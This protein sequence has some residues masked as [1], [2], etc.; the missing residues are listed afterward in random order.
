MDKTFEQ[1]SLWKRNLANHGEADPCAQARERLRQAFIKTRTAVIPLVAQI[2]KELPDLTVHDISHLDALWDVADVLMGDDFDINPAETF[3]LGM[4]FLMHDAAC[5]TFAF[6]DGLDNL[7]NTPEW[8][9]FVAQNNFDEEAMKKGGIGYQRTLFETLRLLHA[10]QAE[11]LLTQSWT[12][13][14]GVQRYLMDDVE[15]RNHY[16]RDIGK[17]AASHGKDAAVAEH[18]WANAAPLTPHACLKLDAKTAWKVDSLKIAMLLR[19]IDAAHID[20][21]RAPDMLASIAP[22]SG[23][24]A[25]YWRFQNR[26]GDVAI[27]K[28]DE[29][30]WSGQTFEEKASDA[31]WLCYDTAR[32]IDREIRNANII[33]TNNDRTP[34]RAKGVAGAQDAVGFS[35]NVPVQGW[36]PIDIGYQISQIGDVIEKFGGAKLYGQNPHLALRE[37]IQN[38]ADAIRARR[39]YRNKPDLG[40][41]DITLTEENGAWWLHVQDSGIGM[42]RYVLTDVLLDFGRSLWADASLREEWAGLAG[43]KFEAV[44]QF[45]I[46]FFSVFMLGDEIKVT[47]WRDGDAEHNQATLHLRQRTNG[48]PIL[49]DTPATQR[50]SEFGTRVSVRL[51]NGRATLLKTVDSGLSYASTEAP[52]HDMT[53]SE[54]VGVLAPALDIDVWCQDGLDAPFRV[55]EANDWRALPPLKLLQRLA[56]AYSEKILQQWTDDFADIIEQDGSIVGR[57]SMLGSHLHRFGHNLGVLAYKG[58]AMGEC[59]FSGILLSGNNEDLARNLARP[60]CSAEALQSWARTIY[61]QTKPPIHPWRSH[62]FLSLG[63]SPGQL[64]LAVLAG[65]Y[66]TP[67]EIEEHLHQFELE[68][69]VIALE[70][71]DCPDSMSKSDFDDQFEFYDEVIDAYYCRGPRESFG[72][73]GWIGSL[74]PETDGLPRTGTAALSQCILH[75]W[76]NATC[77]EENRVVGIAGYNE[78]EIKCLVFRKDMMAMSI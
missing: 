8:V 41:I 58:I 51:K 26:L 48:K 56:P 34:L 71:P 73:H 9:D 14:N 76:P 65:K 78:I 53:L 15:L 23:E 46:G 33:L 13:L 11:K 43:K 40:R 17:I 39:A 31:W 4:T 36:Q 29:I 49:L 12:D 54:T 44:G 72:L 7:R 69:V 2:A 22:P 50:L 38:A 47:T 35:R 63:I 1:S 55:I 18:Y 27:D 20:G 61:S 60:I 66:V 67:E 16:G 19:C 62:Y 57:A 21:C 10:R 74:L 3:V 6:P 24:S 30:Y 70:T 59:H 68:E 37:L 42:S 28:Q 52:T 77:D 45:G 25:D 75:A 32:M 64:P 5:T